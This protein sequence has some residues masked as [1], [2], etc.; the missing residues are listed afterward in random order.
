MRKNIGWNFIKMFTK[1]A[2]FILLILFYIYI[3]EVC[4]HWYPENTTG[5]SGYRGN[6]TVDTLASGSSRD[7]FIDSETVQ[8]YR[9]SNTKITAYEH[10]R[11]W[12]TLGCQHAKALMDPKLPCKW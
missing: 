4:L 6:E 5:H 8:A 10:Q 11:Y 1:L 7:K 3:N 9:K 12:E 2:S